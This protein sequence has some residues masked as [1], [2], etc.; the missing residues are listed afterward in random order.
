MRYKSW[1][2]PKS[3]TGGKIVQ[4]KEEKAVAQKKASQEGGPRARKGMV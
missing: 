3:T 4:N 2:K 1:R